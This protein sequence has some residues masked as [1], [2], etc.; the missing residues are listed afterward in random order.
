MSPK[1]NRNV[2]ERAAR[3]AQRMGVRGEEIDGVFRIKLDAG[4]L[5][6]WEGRTSKEGQKIYRRTLIGVARGIQRF[7]ATDVDIVGPD[8][9][10]LM[11]FDR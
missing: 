3:Y 4:E 5:E 9:K 8:G 10:I 6:L 2:T 7:N 11:R 1:R